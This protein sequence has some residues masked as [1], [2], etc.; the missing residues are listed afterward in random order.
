MCDISAA[1]HYAVFVRVDENVHT[2]II[3]AIFRVTGFLLEPIAA[4]FGQKA[5]AHPG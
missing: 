1:V 4:L 5:A 2:S 3:Y